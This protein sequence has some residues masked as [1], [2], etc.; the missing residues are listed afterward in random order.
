LIALAARLST[1]VVALLVE[2]ARSARPLAPSH[3]TP[4]KNQKHKLNLVAH[5]FFKMDQNYL[6]G[7]NVEVTEGSQYPCPAGQ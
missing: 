5:N 1:A 4:A 7:R 2:L 6:E 3:A